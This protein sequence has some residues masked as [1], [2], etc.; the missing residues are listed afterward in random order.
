MSA[1]IKVLDALDAKRL[2]LQPKENPLLPA[3]I[4]D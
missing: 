4:D 1:A 3:G 2:K